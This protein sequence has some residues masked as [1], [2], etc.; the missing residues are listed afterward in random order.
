MVVDKFRS[1]IDH[2]MSY[3]YIRENL[4][5]DKIT[6]F[7]RS[8]YADCQAIRGD[9]IRWCRISAT[10]ADYDDEGRPHHVLALLQDVDKEKAKEAEYQARIEQE[11]REA[12]IANNAKSEFLRRISHDIRTP[13][14]G[15]RGYIELG[16]AHPDDP[17]VQQHCR[18]SATTALNTLL[19]FVN[20]LFEMSK[21][22]NG[23]I[24]LD[25][26]PFD[27]AELL[28]EVNIVII[29]QAQAKDISYE[30][31]RREDLPVT[32]LIGSPRHVK[33][34]LCNLTSNAVKFGRNGGYVRVNT[35]MIS[36]TDDEATFE[37]TCSD[38]G[39]GMSGDFQA[40]LFEPFSQEAQTARTTYQGAG[41]GL[42]IVK[43]LV[44]ALGGT[45]ACH[46][47]KDVGTTFSVV[48]TFRID[49]EYS[50]QDAHAEKYPADCLGGL[51]ILLV[52]DNELNM[53]IAELML[54]EHGAA[55]TKAWN[56]QEAVDAF[57]TS[58]VGFYDAICIDIMM[59][60][61]DGMTAARTI[62]ALDRDDAGSVPILAMSAN[63]FQ[64]DVRASLDAGIS[65]HLAKPLVIND[66][67]AA[68]SRFCRNK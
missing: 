53:E 33:Q 49:K 48:L 56:G 5:R 18:D 37:F 12:K 28:S 27:I 6:D 9:E 35:R 64:D 32:R 3:G 20:S 45:I 21:L 68:L 7:R 59:P 44:D 39:V 8:F 25:E 22:E 58:A 50:G 41:L 63:A 55:V 24:V 10:V 40:H 57:R 62:R 61:M 15:I 54:S 19:E 60:V 43:K 42:S 36:R 11:A 16:A 51:N 14:N 23:D 38:N 1:E 66:V 13:I 26:K 31:L 52:E 65:A 17:A 4:S 47:E 2:V 30:I 46:S 67:M 29:P 34:I